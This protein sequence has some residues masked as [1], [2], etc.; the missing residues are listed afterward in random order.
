MDEEI[1]CNQI[2]ISN[3]KSN[4]MKKKEQFI[5]PIAQMSPT[6]MAKFE[7]PTSPSAAIGMRD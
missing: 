4:N 3:F 5:Q 7:P 2:P 1:A 6:G